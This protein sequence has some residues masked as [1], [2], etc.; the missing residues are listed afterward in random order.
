MN[1]QPGAILQPGQILLKNYR[2]TKMLG[3]GGMGQVFAAEDINRGVP[4]A[5]KVPALNIVTAP[6]G[7]ESFLSEAKK[8]AP[9][10]HQHIVT[11]LTCLTDDQLHYQRIPI[12]FIIMEFL[13]GG[14][15]THLLGRG[16]MA[17]DHAFKLFE[18]MCSAVHYA[19]FY[20]NHSRGI[21]GLIHR[22]LK[23]QN[24]CFTEGGE[25]VIVDF[26]LSKILTDNPSLS[27]GI[28]G[29]PTHMSP[30]Q[31]SPKRKVDHRT[32]IYALGIILFEMLTGQ[33]PFMGR[34][35][36]EFL[37]MHMFEAPPDPR[38]FRRDV[39]AGVAEAILRSLAKEK[40]Q[41]FNTAEEFALAVGSGFGVPKREEIRP[42]VDNPPIQQP[43]PQ[44]PAQPGPKKVPQKPPPS[45]SMTPNAPANIHFG[46]DPLGDGK[47][48]DSV[49]NQSAEPKNPARKVNQQKI[50]IE[51]GLFG[52]NQKDEEDEQSIENLSEAE[53]ENEKP[54]SDVFTGSSADDSKDS[55]EP[56]KPST[57]P[58][59]RSA[60]KT[61]GAPDLGLFA[62]SGNS[63]EEENQV[64]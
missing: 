10:R 24:I 21:K 14:D 34:S 31:W 47:A 63:K 8:A 58:S 4:V 52:V 57:K 53:Q 23:P 46:D 13:G 3:A 16:Q 44:H 26:G 61:S 56:Q 39:P 62:G 7:P 40:E 5:V 45:F 27:G 22:D 59:P 32:D 55:H 60:R 11:I 2:V 35:M 25:V 15:L 48:F 33:L 30:E 29:T 6:N 41:R 36:E 19:H 54:I 9:L 12:P 64:D 17:L 43:V 37:A 51:S 20:E 50:D 28:S 1:Y 49:V 18:Q 38:N 42:A